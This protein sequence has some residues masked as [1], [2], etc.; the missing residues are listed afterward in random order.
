MR[1]PAPTPN[2]APARANPR[3]RSPAA[4]SATSPAKSSRS[5]WKHSHLRIPRRLRL[6]K[7]RG[8]IT[9]VLQLRALLLPGRLLLGVLLDQFGLLPPQPGQFLLLRFLQRPASA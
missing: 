9:L 8:V 4:S 1:A 6:D 5:S 2:A 3:K 7:H